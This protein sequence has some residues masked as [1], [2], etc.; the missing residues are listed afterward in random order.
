MGKADEMS[1]PK[2]SIAPAAVWR[3]HFRARR[4]SV[5]QASS[6]ERFITIVPRRRSL[7]STGIN[8]TLQFKV[9]ELVSGNIVS[10]ES[11]AGTQN[12]RLDKRVSVFIVDLSL[13]KTVARNLQDSLI[14]QHSHTNP[15]AR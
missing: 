10:Y 7:T 13:A 15:W 9:A 2:T 14:P 5:G 3:R 12:A 8:V 11:A 4:V 1:L 6:N